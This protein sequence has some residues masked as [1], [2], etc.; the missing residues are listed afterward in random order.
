MSIYLR[1]NSLEKALAV[2]DE[3]A[4]RPPADRLTVL[5][6]ATDL[7]PAET[8]R[9]AWFQPS[10]SNILDIAALTELRGIVQAGDSLRIGALTTWSD[11][12]N[13]DLPLA[14]D[15]LKQASRQVG[16][17]QIQNR[18]TIG[19]NLCNASPAADGIP[20]L[21]ALD[22]AVELASSKGTRRLPLGN[23][24]LGNRKTALRDDE[25][26]TAIIIPKPATLERAIFAKLGAR[27]YLVISIA[28]VAVNV[29]CDERDRII[30]TRIA[31]GACSA[32]PQ[33]LSALEPRLT[34]TLLA[35]AASVVGPDD[36]NCLA[37]LDDV[38]ASAA[39]RIS[40][41]ATLVQRA[42]HD[43]LPHHAVAA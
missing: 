15:G 11:I 20:P 14:F 40:A 30:T 13:A 31:V 5:A 42:L 3:A 29:I 36:F 43:L 23:F 12:I 17:V 9:S 6:G 19:G 41:A 28:S 34:G 8:T 4:A 2:L 39:Y 1:P 38:R 22:A 18:G 16:G 21:L 33:R 25:L 26:L 27:S 32:I 7:L 10:P 24:I 37:P 35:D